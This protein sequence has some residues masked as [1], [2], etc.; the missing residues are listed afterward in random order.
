MDDY[1][2][3]NQLVCQSINN[4]QFVGPQKSGLTNDVSRTAVR[5]PVP[6]MQELVLLLVFSRLMNRERRV[7]PTT[8]KS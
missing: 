7:S 8:L 4:L 2:L 6:L 5:P 3:V 1:C